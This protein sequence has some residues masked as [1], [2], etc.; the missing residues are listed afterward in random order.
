MEDWSFV[1]HGMIAMIRILFVLRL[2]ECLVMIGI[3]FA[4]VFEV[5][6]CLRYSM[7]LGSEFWILR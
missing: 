7:V 3:K 6:R 5:L 2:L 1:T 4:L